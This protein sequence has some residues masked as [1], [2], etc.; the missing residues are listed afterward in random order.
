M[1]PWRSRMST[2]VANAPSSRSTTSSRG[3]GAGAGGKTAEIDEHD[4]DPADLA[5]GAFAF[6]HQPLD[7]LRRDVLAEQVGDAVARRRR[8]DA[9]FELAAQLQPHRARQHAANQDH[10]TTDDMEGQIRRGLR[11]RIAPGDTTSPWRTIG[12]RD[13]AGESGKPEIKPQSRED[14]E[15]EIGQRHH[16]GRA[17]APAPSPSSADTSAT[18][19][20]LVSIRTPR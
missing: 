10:D 20:R 19:G 12:R 8:E 2:S 1:P 4:G 3:A 9:G 5:V 13:E 6:R 7:H 16:E 14:D 18:V 11:R 17:P 15:N